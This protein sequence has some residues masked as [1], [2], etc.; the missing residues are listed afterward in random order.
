MT[1]TTS[2]AEV[3][4]DFKRDYLAA[5]ERLMATLED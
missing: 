1:Q 2:A 4:Q 5:T 3:V